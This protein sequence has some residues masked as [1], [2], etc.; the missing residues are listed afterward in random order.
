LGTRLIDFIVGLLLTALF[1]WLWL[2]AHHG[3][4]KA[5]RDAG[6]LGKP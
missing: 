3:W 4:N 5:V 2:S 1:V 6:D